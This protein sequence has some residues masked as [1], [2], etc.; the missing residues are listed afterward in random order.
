MSVDT[1]LKS[2][3]LK[4]TSMRKSFVIIF[5]VM[6]KQSTMRWLDALTSF[7]TLTDSVNI[8]ERVVCV[9]EISQVQD[10]GQKNG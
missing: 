1:C 7:F 2:T 6:L 3:I 9:K 5:A 10:A 4:L 8:K